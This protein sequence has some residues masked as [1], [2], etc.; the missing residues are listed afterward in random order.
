MERIANGEAKQCAI[1]LMRGRVPLFVLV[2]SNLLR[3]LLGQ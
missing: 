3:G 2:S 1:V